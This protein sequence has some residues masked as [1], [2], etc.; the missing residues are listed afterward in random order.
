MDAKYKGF[1]VPDNNCFRT[2]STDVSSW[3]DICS[4]FVFWYV[5]TLVWIWIETLPSQC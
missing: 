2:V 3:C 4:K 5:K 1:T